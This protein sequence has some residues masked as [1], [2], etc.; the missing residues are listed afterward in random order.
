[1]S[2]LDIDP[3][4][5]ADYDRVD[6]EKREAAIRSTNAAYNTS[7][8][9]ATINQY[10]QEQQIYFARVF[11]EDPTIEKATITT[12]PNPGNGFNEFYI[13]AWAK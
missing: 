10:D 7:V 1:M 9:N 8:G 4:H 6:P 3:R 11:Y 2:A 5:Y 13:E 12:T